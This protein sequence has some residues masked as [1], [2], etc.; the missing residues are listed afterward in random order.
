VVLQGGLSV[1]GRVVADVSKALPNDTKCHSGTS[2]KRPLSSDLFISLAVLG[3][4]ARNPIH[5]RTFMITVMIMVII[6]AFNLGCY[7]AY[8]D[9]S[10]LR[11]TQHT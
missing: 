11:A 10:N 1:V 2:H 8:G 9:V 6:I 4:L 5:E 7:V 3:K